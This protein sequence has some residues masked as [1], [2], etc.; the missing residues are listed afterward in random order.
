MVAMS[1]SVSLL[2][3]GGIGKN[4]FYIAQAISAIAYVST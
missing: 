2:E 4:K 1:L 3:T